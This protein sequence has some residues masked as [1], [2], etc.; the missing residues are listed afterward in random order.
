MKFQQ[1]VRERTTD[2][3]KRKSLKNISAIAAIASFGVTSATGVMA[4]TNHFDSGE[5]SVS[6]GGLIENAVKG[7]LVSKTGT[8]AETLV[9]HNLTERP[10]A[11]HHFHLNEVLFDGDIVDCNNACS[12]APIVIPAKKVVLIQFNSNLVSALSSSAKQVDLNAQLYHLWQGTRVVP[13]TGHL[14]ADGGV[15]LTAQAATQAA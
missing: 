2:E 11:I 6:S 5:S 9:L 13:F 1:V 8:S 4:S 14:T 15:L 10:V 12:D 3:S 7:M